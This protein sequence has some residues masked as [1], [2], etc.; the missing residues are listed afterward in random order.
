MYY[1]SIVFCLLFSA[2][3]SLKN[4]ECGVDSSDMECE[5]SNAEQFASLVNEPFPADN[6]LSDH[7]RYEH[8]LVQR[9]ATKEMSF[10]WSPAKKF[11][12]WRKL[13]IALATA[14]QELGLDITDEQLSELRA[15]L[16]DIDFDFAEEKERE[17]RHDVMAHVH[18]FGEGTKA[19]PIIHLGATSC[20]VTDNT[21]LVQI[22][23]SLLLVK[24]KL[25]QTIKILREFAVA[26]R[27]LP[28][29]GFTHYQ[30]AQ[31]TTVGK[32]CTLWM[33]DLLLDLDKLDSEINNLPFRGVKGTTGT[34]ASF[35][36]LFDGD[37]EKVKAL[38][39]RVT[40]LMGFEKVIPVSGQT[41]TRKIDYN[42]LS[43]LSGIAQSAYKMCGDIRLLSNLKEIEE[44]FSKTQI[45]S[46][47]M[48]YKRNPMR[49]ERVA[50]L[51][52]YVMGLPSMA[53]STHSNQW[54]E[55]TLDDSAIRRMYLPEGFLA[56]DVILNLLSNI[57][58]GLHVWPNVIK[59][60]VMAELPFMAT[61]VILMECVKNKGNRQELHE[62][63][64]V[65][66][67]A[68]GDVVKG[69]GKPN[70][71][72]ERIAKDPLFAAVHAVLDRLVDPKLFVG[73][74]PEQVD[75]FIFEQIDPILAENK[76]LLEVPSIDGITV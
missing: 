33:Q 14:E 57:S 42:I 23:E 75:D 39:I 40:E 64:R 21:E 63:I 25:L 2:A 31:L 55:R 67:M 65:H 9:Y 24:R 17:F 47:A 60:H 4:N 7:Q 28:T 50:S 45:G 15:K 59:A 37:H 19:M 49:S 16:Y 34:Q 26:H 6:V 62:A 36:E 3:K 8:P 22:K 58:D 69:E 70:D 38:D 32:R 66:S 27:D 52:R 56:I 51:A 74:A 43:V 20:F 46:S 10:I 71:L 44:P 68:A 1:G 13:W 30:P 61:E 35:L 11:T 5:R 29:L 12:T 41:Y 72:L 18:T 48:A 54:F 53:A 73:R 76:E